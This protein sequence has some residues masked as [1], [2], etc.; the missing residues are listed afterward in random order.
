VLEL[1]VTSKLLY[2]L[3]CQALAWVSAL[4]LV[5]N[6]MYIL[7]SNNPTCVE[8]K[9]VKGRRNR[10]KKMAGHILGHH[11][12]GFLYYACHGPI[13]NDWY[14][15]HHWD[16]V[17]SRTIRD[18]KPDENIHFA[19]QKLSADALNKRSD[20]VCLSRLYS[21]LPGR[22]GVTGW[23]HRFLPVLGCPALSRG[24]LLR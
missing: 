4:L 3:T 16:K 22:L 5:Q 20:R 11:Q 17:Q 19:K 2:P 24:N 13:M 12:P 14:K 21:A 15:K 6:M 10:I 23:H 1:C 8:M 9:K 7:E 18:D